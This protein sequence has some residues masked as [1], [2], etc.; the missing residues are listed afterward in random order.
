[1][2]LNGAQDLGQLGRAEFAG[3]ARPVAIPRETYLGHFEEV[4]HL[5]E[6]TLSM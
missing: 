2:A 5:T 4:K 6:W 1:M 3:S